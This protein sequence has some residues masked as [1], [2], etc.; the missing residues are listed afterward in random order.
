MHPDY[1]STSF[2]VELDLPAIPV[3]H[4]HAHIASV[5]AEHRLDEKV[6]GVSFDGTGLG[7]DGNIWGSEFFVCD[8]SGF[9]R[10]TH[11]DYMPMPGGD[12]AAKE[13]W[14]MAF[15]LLY[16]SY[17]R[18]M[19]KLDL[20]FLQSSG[21]ADKE[22]L[23]QAIEKGINCPLTSG[24]GRLF[25]AVA[26]L[27][28]ICRVSVFHAE[29]PMRLENIAVMTTGECYPYALNETIDIKPV[30]MG[31]AEDILG[32]KD[33]GRI[34]GRF[35]NT[36]SEIIVN[37]VC[38]IRESHGIEKAVLSGGTFQNRLISRLTENAL[39]EKGFKV[40]IPGLLPA[41][42]GGIALGQLA[43]AARKRTF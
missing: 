11:L 23:L 36:V 32:G 6:I 9:E 14:R 35:H 12:R 37:T 15:S 34:S 4:H 7:E 20:P 8:L 28:G 31:I 1:L 24:A 39:R 43:V 16:A 25:D 17:G 30:I 21:E 2:A 42:D 38:R 3:Q 27:L 33:P 29:A 10:I 26:A 18:D 13:P 5:M 40:Y 19:M 22:L 41:N